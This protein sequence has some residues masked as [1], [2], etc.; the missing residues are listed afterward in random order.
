MQIYRERQMVLIEVVIGQVNN[1]A[2]RQVKYLITKITK[3]NIK[4]LI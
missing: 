4:K 1:Q 3:V 2:G